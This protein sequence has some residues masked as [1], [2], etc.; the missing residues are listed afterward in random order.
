MT[1]RGQAQAYKD[2]PQIG[3]IIAVGHNGAVYKLSIGRGERVDRSIVSEYN[4][5]MED[6]G[7]DTHKVMQILAKK[8]IGAMKKYEQALYIR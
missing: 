2:N 3:T 7:K 4:M 6:T 1:R 5:L 8:T